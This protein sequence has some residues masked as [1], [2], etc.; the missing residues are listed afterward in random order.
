[1]LGAGKEGAAHDQQF[2]VGQRQRRDG[3]HQFVDAL[4][5][6]KAAAVKDDEILIGKA[7]LGAQRFGRRAGVK[8]VRINAV[9]QNVGALV[10]N[11]A[12]GKVLAADE[13]ADGQHAAIDIIH[14]RGA[15]CLAVQVR[16]AAPAAIHTA[17]GA[18][19]GQVAALAD[20]QVGRGQFQ[21]EGKLN[22]L[23]PGV[24]GGGDADAPFQKDHWPV[25]AV[26]AGARHVKHFGVLPALGSAAGDIVGHTG[27]QKLQLTLFLVFTDQMG[28]Q[29]FHRT[30]LHRRHRQIRRRYQ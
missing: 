29:G 8:A 26:P 11:A 10:V 19:L 27:A 18:A 21:C 17:D 22:F 14:D 7:Q 2:D 28:Q 25:A 6:V 16:Q 13:L 30:A 20:N 3:L 9:M 5:R 23:I 1:M 15:V 12:G 4:V 24:I